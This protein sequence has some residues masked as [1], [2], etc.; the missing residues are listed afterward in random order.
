MHICI[1]WI[2][3]A[4]RACNSG[5]Q[6]YGRNWPLRKTMRRSGA[7]QRRG[8]ARP[9]DR[10]V[11][12]RNMAWNSIV[13]SIETARRLC[14]S[15]RRQTWTHD[16]P[17]GFGTNATSLLGND[18]IR[19]YGPMK[20]SELKTTQRFGVSGLPHLRQRRRWRSVCLRQRLLWSKK[21]QRTHLSASPFK[22]IAR[23][24]KTDV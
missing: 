4:D 24:G 6:I 16:C 9:G 13:R 18:N 8:E 1:H 21:S 20:C 7:A 23:Q 22:S 15:A 12:V 3:Y 5:A 11:E 2:R 17:N 14:N 10:S 19:W